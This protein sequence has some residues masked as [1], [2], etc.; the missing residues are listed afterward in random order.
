M[1]DESW[2]QFV[3]DLNLGPEF[4]EF[5]SELESL[6][7]YARSRWGDSGIRFWPEGGRS[8]QIVVDLRYPMNRHRREEI[9]EQMA[10]TAKTKNREG[11]AR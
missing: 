4:K 6:G 9:L 10:S 5:F 3:G 1:G 7:W 8:R 11:G 2:E